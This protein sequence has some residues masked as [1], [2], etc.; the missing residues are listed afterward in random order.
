MNILKELTKDFQFE[1]NLV[2][3]EIR[4][5]ISGNFRV[6]TLAPAEIKH[7]LNHGD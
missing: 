1:E 5:L 4:K 3:P 6:I 2:N 7:G